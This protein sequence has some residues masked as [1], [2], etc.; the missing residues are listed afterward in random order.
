[1]ETK[2]KDEKRSFPS[3][4]TE[5]KLEELRPVIEANAQALADRK[6]AAWTPE[7]RE[8]LRKLRER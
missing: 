5:E 1:M 2:V 6:V 3:W 8:A 4:F 7:F